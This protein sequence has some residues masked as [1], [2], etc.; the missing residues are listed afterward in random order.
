MQPPENFA[1]ESPLWS[2][3]IGRAVL[4]LTVMMCLYLAATV[5]ATRGELINALEQ[6]P[7][8]VLPN[9][10]GLVLAGWILRA[11]RWQYYVRLL[12][13]DI[14]LH[15]SMY[16]F[17][18]SFAFTATPGKAGE[19]IK[20]VLL[21]TR[22]QVPLAEG[23]GVLL[24]ERLGDL[25]AVIIMATG[26]LALLAD[27]LIYF[28]ISVILVGGMTVFVSVRAIY[29]PIFCGWQEFPNFRARRINCSGFSTLAARFCVPG[30]S[31][32]AW[33]SP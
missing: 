26:G 25:L 27:A 22:H 19:V 4:V 16:A 17:F 21:R 33:A 23:V 30:L 32:W 12:R 29:V 2:R 11:L 7:L 14:P 15:H 24:V 18:A 9:I 3:W 10:V 5:W 20:S 1:E 8:A 28:V 6:L 13:W 31:C